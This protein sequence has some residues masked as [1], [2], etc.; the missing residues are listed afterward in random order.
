MLMKHPS[1]RKMIRGRKR[2]EKGSKKRRTTEKQ[3]NNLKKP[4][5]GLADHK[6]PLLKYTNYHALNVP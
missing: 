1:T 6:A 4:R 3:G 5:S 2:R